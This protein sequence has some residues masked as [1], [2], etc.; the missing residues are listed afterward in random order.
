[1]DAV[2]YSRRYRLRIHRDLHMIGALYSLAKYPFSI[3]RHHS[4]DESSYVGN[5]AKEIAPQV[6]KVVNEPKTTEELKLPL[7]HPVRC[8][9]LVAKPS[10]QAEHGVDG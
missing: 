5:M 4:L 8:R 6:Y 7:S 9:S 10:P 3:S 2:S 1:M